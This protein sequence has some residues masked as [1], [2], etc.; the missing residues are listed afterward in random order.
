MKNNS[1]S[2]KFTEFIRNN[3]NEIGVGIALIVL[4]I[5]FSITSPYFLKTKNLYNILYQISAI[6][7][8]AIAQTMVL[9][10]GGI[11]L[12]IGS[13][14]T[15]SGWVMCFLVKEVGLAEGLMAGLA[16]GILCGF[17]NGFLVSVT[18]LEPFIVT[19]G[20][21]S[22][23]HGI[24]YIISNSKAVSNLP[25]ILEKIDNFRVFGIPS[26][27]LVLLIVFLLSYLFLTYTK[28]GRMIYAI[29]SNELSA[30]Y[31]GVP[32]Y[33]YKIVP[34]IIV[35]FLAFVAVF[36][37]SA[38]LMAIDA[39]AGTNLNLDSITAVVIGGTSLQGGRGSLAVSYT[40]L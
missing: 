37:Q 12:S 29:G 27:V 19:L 4:F 22:I 5:V 36:I 6:G 39:N 1:Q 2:K 34:Y 16:I 14:F 40:H 24:V 25:V 35:G 30:R 10:T 8:L 20:T 21:M 23:Y 7:I 32:V 11:D 9:L 17:I 15:L 3:S 13:T 26:Y 33:A 31:S 38:H 28:T 18:Q